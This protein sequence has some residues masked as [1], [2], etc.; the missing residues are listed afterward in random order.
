MEKL[1]GGVWRMSG[2]LT[3]T[4]VPELVESIS[5]EPGAAGKR[6]QIDLGGVSHADSAGLALLVCWLRR[7][8]RRGIRILF[9][10]VPEQLLRIA[11]V[12]GLDTVLPF[13]KDIE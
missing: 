3:F 13:G 1:P 6:L 11:R 4:T 5:M 10:G 2:E 9:C 12:S 7:A 8:R